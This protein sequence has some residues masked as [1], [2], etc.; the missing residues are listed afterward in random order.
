M[1]SLTLLE[2]PHPKK[3]KPCESDMDCLKSEACYMS[4]CQDP[5]EFTNVCAS[6]AKCQAKMHRPICTCP[7]GY[8]GNPAIKCFKATP[9]KINTITIHSR[10]SLLTIVKVTKVTFQ[11]KFSYRILVTVSVWLSTFYSTI[12][13]TCATSGSKWL[14]TRCVNWH[15]LLQEASEQI[16]Q[17]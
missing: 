16:R 11:S 3:P 12:T 6:T 1:I 9:S 7:M 17:C 10:I 15:G 8:E 4:V 5:C 14:T 13:F 2:P